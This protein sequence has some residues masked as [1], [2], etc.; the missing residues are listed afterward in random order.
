MNELLTRAGFSDAACDGAAGATAREAQRNR[1]CELRLAPYFEEWRRLTHALGPEDCLFLL[2]SE[3][4]ATSPD[5]DAVAMAKALLSIAQRTS[6]AAADGADRW[7]N[8]LFPLPQ[9][10]AAIASLRPFL[11]RQDAAMAGAVASAD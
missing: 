3:V 6:G 10:D 5:S 1:L 4:A 9:P 11:A 7:V 8:P 2:A